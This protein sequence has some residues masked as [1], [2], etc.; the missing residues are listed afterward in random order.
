MG[1]GYGQILAEGPALYFFDFGEV[2]KGCLEILAAKQV[3]FFR[4]VELKIQCRLSKM[5]ELPNRVQNF[6]IKVASE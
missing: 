5:V 1:P 2:C 6:E 4:W 3:R